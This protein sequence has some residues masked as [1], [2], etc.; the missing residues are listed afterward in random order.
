VSGDGRPESVNRLKRRPKSPGLEENSLAAAAADAAA[1]LQVKVWL[2]AWFKIVGFWVT[3]AR[4]SSRVLKPDSVDKLILSG[5]QA[6]PPGS[7]A[8]RRH[9]KSWGQLGVIPEALCADRFCPIA[10]SDRADAF[11]QSHQRVPGIAARIDDRF[12]VFKH[13]VAQEVLP[14]VLPNVLNRV[15]LR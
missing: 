2:T 6:G 7:A 4:W 10:L 9:T 5:R 8:R 11:W 3:V 15:E 14:E 13:S 12:V 1:V